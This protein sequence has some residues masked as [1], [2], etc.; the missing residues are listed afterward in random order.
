MIDHSFIFLEGIGSKTEE[1]L[2]KN[3]IRTWD[4]FLR[5]SSIPGIT[6]RRKAYYDQQLLQ[7]KEAL[8]QQNMGFFFSCLPQR[9]MWRLYQYFRDGCCFFDVE[10]DGHGKIIVLTLFD[11]F[12]S[13]TLVKGMGLEREVIE[14]ELQKYTLL[15]TYNGSAFDIPHIKKEF[16]LELSLPHIDLKPLCQRLGLR[17]G[18]KEI[19]RQL[20]INRPSHLHGHPVDLWKAFW[21]SGDREWLELLVQYN[22]EDAVNLYH[23][24][25]KC[26]V[27]MRAFYTL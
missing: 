11:R 16:H 25:E 6:L 8:Y 27:R 12:Q 2:W 15:V 23:L 10:V 9:E 22:E 14:K 17:G 24:L 4:D 26:L 1:K 20:G 5:S 13:K 21:A 19:E 18:L 3:G 7:A